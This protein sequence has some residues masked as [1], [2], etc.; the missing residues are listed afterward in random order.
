MQPRLTDKILFP[1]VVLY[2]KTFRHVGAHGTVG[3]KVAAM[4][5][6]IKNQF[7]N[8]GSCCSEF[9]YVGRYLVNF[10]IRMLK[11]KPKMKPWFPTKVFRP[12]TIH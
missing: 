7:L 6:S 4:E 8:R 9:Y 2:F 12:F 5:G 10:S 1:L 3:Q 11:V